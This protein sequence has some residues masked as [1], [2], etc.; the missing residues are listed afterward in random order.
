MKETEFRIIGAGICGHQKFSGSHLFLEG[1]YRNIIGVNVADGGFYFCCK[2]LASL[3]LSFQN[4]F[5]NFL[6]KRIYDVSR[7]G[8][9]NAK[10]IF[11]FAK[12][13]QFFNILLFVLYGLQRV[14]TANK[15]FPAR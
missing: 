6:S 13:R 12:H 3:R 7:P 2:G 11:P 1:H 15:A 5:R 9:S 8:S 4:A 14:G 10:W